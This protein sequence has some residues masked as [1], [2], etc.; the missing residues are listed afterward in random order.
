[1][2]LKFYLLDTFRFNDQMNRQMLVKIAQLPDSAECIRQFSHLINSQNKWMARILQ[3]PAAPVMS[4]WDPVYPF[5]ELETRWAESLQVWTGFLEPKS[6]EEIEREVEFT[7]FE[8]NRWVARLSD[9]ALQLNYHSI[10]HRAQM[11]VDIRNQGAEPDFIDYIGTKFRQVSEG[12]DNDDRLL[13]EVE[14]EANPTKFAEPQAHN[15]KI[16]AFTRKLREI[17]EGNPWYGD[18]FKQIVQDI[19]PERALILNHR[20]KSIIQLV[21]HMIFWRRPL[22]ERLKGNPDF[23][24]TVN[25]PENWFKNRIFK[26]EDWPAALEAF[27]RQHTALLS[28]LSDQKDEFLETEYRDGR[29]MEWLVEGVIQHDLYH[30]GQ[31]ALLGSRG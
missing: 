13:P 20:N 30:L 8:G 5:E 22:L 26:P 27:D 2:F 15:E 10:H 7:G 29:T 31:I 21:W 18:S 16:T 19:D 6:D 12:H 17:Y 14:P 4:W 28:L 24:A 3:D 25:D 1:M 9:I 11:Q 23:K